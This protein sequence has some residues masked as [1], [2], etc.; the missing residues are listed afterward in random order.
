MMKRKTALLTATSLIFYALFAAVIVG[1]FSPDFSTATILCS[2]DKPECP[3]EYTCEAPYCV[4]KST[5]GQADQAVGSTDAAMNADMAFPPDMTTRKGC[6]DGKGYPVGSAWACPGAWGPYL[7]PPKPAVSL[8]ASGFSVCKSA[9]PFISPTALQ[10]C[11][12]LKGFYVADMFANQYLDN[13][14]TCTPGM[15][16]RVIYG[17]GEAARATDF[18]TACGFFAQAMECDRGR[19]KTQIKCDLAF[20]KIDDL[21]NRT[22]VDGVLCCPL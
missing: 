6:A 2:A 5:A 22:G 1:C 3:P 4:P 16:Y 9:N 11:R 8:C 12:S 17:C 14:P 19:N 10:E 15:N 18:A 7:I 13:A 21:D 20:G